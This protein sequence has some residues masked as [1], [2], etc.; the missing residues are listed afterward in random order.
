MN[1]RLHESELP[2][3]MVAPGILGIPMLEPHYEGNPV[4]AEFA[5]PERMRKHW[6]AV[7]DNKCQTHIYDERRGWY[8]CGST[9]DIEV[10]HLVEESVQLENGQDPNNSVG[11][12]RCHEHHCGTGLVRDRGELRYAAYGEREWS[13]HPDMGAALQA[14]RKGDKDA[15]KIAALRHHALA[16]EGKAVSNI[17]AEVIQW[18][19]DYMLKLEQEYIEK[20]HNKRP[21][22]KP[23]PRFKRRYSQ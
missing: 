9:R 20:T 14:Y 18:E 17:S 23:H 4:S 11:I 10:D 3:P 16:K 7:G 15:F 12:P 5:Y 1:E 6:R 21:Q 8:I 13:R 2:I 19:T 22:M